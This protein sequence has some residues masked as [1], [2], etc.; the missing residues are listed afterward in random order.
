LILD[1]R[2]VGIFSAITPL[3]LGCIMLVYLRERKVYGGFGRWILANFSLAFGYAFI[4]LRDLIPDFLSIVLGNLLIVYSAILIYEG[5]E[6]FNDRPPFSR[7]NYLVLG[8]YIVLQLT[9]TYAVPD[10]NLRVAVSSLVLFMLILRSGQSLLLPS[11]PE[12]QWTLRSAGYVF[13][14][15]ALFPLV[16]GT[17]ALFQSGPITFFMDDVN[18]WFS[19]VFIVAIVA[20]TFFFFFLNSARIELEL[21]TARIELDKIARTDPLTSLYNRRHF[22]EHAE[23]EFQ[24]ARRYG[25][26]ISFL[27]L[28]VDNFKLVNDGKGHGVGDEVLLSL[29]ETISSQIRPFDLIARFGRDEFIVMLLD[30]NEEQAY[31][32]GERIRRSVAHTPVV[33]EAHT[34]NISLSVGITTVRT[35]D[36]DLKQILRRTDGAPYRAKQEGRN[37]VRVA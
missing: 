18:A 30:T 3:I 22:D 24:R 37:C 6:L 21:E 33:C 28:D 1:I 14:I 15:T 35:G 27:I 23:R 34:V 4:S 29:A 2:T 17:T 19:P 10:I 16:R 25:Y 36:L 11:I 31:S 32:I 12:L 13:V 26:S 7:L 9:F 5:I 20:W 8:I